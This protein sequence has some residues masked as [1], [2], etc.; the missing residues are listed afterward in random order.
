MKKTRLETLM[1]EY[2]VWYHLKLQDNNRLKEPVLSDW[3]EIKIKETKDAGELILM[4][5]ELSLIK[6][7]K[8]NGSS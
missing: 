3:I 1:H 5:E 8:T 7:L 2:A 4:P 6:K